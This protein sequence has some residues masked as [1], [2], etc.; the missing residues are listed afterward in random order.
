MTGHKLQY[1]IFSYITDIL[2]GVA[3]ASAIAFFGSIIRLALTDSLNSFILL[4]IFSGTAI[5]IRLKLTDDK[6]T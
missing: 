6:F 5:G 2:T 3:T 1:V 4:M